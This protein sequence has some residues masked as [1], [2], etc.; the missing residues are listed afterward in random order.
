MSLVESAK[1]VWRW[2][3]LVPQIAEDYRC[4]KQFR[5]LDTALLHRFVEQ[6][7][8]LWSNRIR[9]ID[10]YNLGLFD[11]AMP[12]ALKRNYIGRYEIWRLFLTFNP[13]EHQYLTAKKLDFNVYA[14][15]ANLPTAEVLAVVS[16]QPS[17][18]GVPSLGTEE[19][20][21][22][23]MAANSVAEVVLKPVDGT[24]GWGVLS[25]GEQVGN[26]QW[27]TLPQGNIM[28]VAA[29]W[30]HCARYLYRG[31]AIIQRRLAPH[32]TL[33]ELMPDVLHTVRVITYLNP[34]PVLID[35]VLRVGNGKGA[36]DNMAQG[37]IVVP[38]NL[39]TGRCGQAMRLVDGLPQ[40]IDN[41]PI[42]GNRITGIVLPDWRQVCD[43]AKAAAQ[44]F[45]M[46]KSIGWD[47]GLTTRGPV[48]LEG[49]SCYD[50]TVNQIA[51]R[52]GILSTCWVDAFNKEGGHRHLGLGF[53]NRP[54]I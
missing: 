46:Q 5:D 25:L 19:E 39:S 28:D 16:K 51:N 10:Y 45:S 32:P 49:N 13:L 12:A 26:G 31:G 47:V 43:L 1:I 7:T 9:A 24:K 27:K 34:Q 48:L 50:L 52:K 6:L 20:F 35:A 30:A 40:R 22:T 11:P 21:R 14:A 33:A 53:G 37:G 36:A 42:S 15:E 3:S 2:G 38:L 44:R 41:H 18:C 54:R 23:W 17:G 29:I 4:H 8:L